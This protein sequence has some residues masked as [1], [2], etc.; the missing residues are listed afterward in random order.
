MVAGAACVPPNTD[1]FFGH[2]MENLG[3]QMIVDMRLATGDD[4]HL[5]AGCRCARVQ[6]SEW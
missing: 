4:L 5:D 3:H 2:D 6:I 1:E